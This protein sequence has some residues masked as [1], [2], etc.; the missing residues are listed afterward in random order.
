MPTQA[1]PPVDT[2][3]D[4]FNHLETE[5]T[6]LGEHLDLSFLER[7]EVCPFG[8]FLVHLYCFHNDIYGQRVVY[9]ALQDETV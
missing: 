4:V 2:V 8:L 6:L 3:E 7:F 9:R 5:S 1:V